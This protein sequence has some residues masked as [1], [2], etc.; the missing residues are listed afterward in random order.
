MNKNP[1]GLLVPLDNL[2][3]LN[4][5]LIS[6]L[7]RI[8]DMSHKTLHSSLQ[9]KDKLLCYLSTVIILRPLN[10]HWAGLTFYV[11]KMFLLNN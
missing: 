9:L 11:K 6:L 1:Q 5:I 3:I 2:I 10:T 8:K 4:Q 7:I